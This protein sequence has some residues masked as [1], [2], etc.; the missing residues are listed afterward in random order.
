MSF[1]LDRRSR[2]TNTNSI[3]NVEIRIP[4]PPPDDNTLFVYDSERDKW[5]LREYFPIT[6]DA[7]TIPQDVRFESGVRFGTNGTLIKSIRSFH[8]PIT[9][10]FSIAA[11][12]RAF[13]EFEQVNPFED[14]V[15][16]FV[17]LET[18][19]PDKGL[20]LGITRTSGVGAINPAINFFNPT[21]S[22]ITIGNP[23]DFVH[24]L[25]IEGFP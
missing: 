10:P 20:L 7:Q 11:N 22:P 8:I 18:Q 17:T 1:H 16:V 15:D 2:V 9:P 23:G 4:P 24:Y 14:S 25:A 5:Q 3:S 12:T 19:N 13:L 6:D 21:G